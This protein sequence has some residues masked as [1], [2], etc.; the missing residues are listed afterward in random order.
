MGVMISGKALKIP[1]ASEVTASECNSENFKLNTYPI[2]KEGI[3]LRR[4]MIALGDFVI[5]KNEELDDPTAKPVRPSRL[6]KRR[7]A[8]VMLPEIE[9]GTS[10]TSLTAVVRTLPTDL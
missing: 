5:F 7:D 4:A 3:L 6:T 1:H 8:S 2:R 9:R 10:L